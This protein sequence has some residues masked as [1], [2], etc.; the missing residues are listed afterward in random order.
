MCRLCTSL[1]P[2]FLEALPAVVIEDTPAACRYFEDVAQAD[3]SAILNHHAHME[4]IDVS[5]LS[6]LLDSE[7]PDGHPQTSAS[8]GKKKGSAGCARCQTL[9]GGFLHPMCTDSVSVS[10][11]SGTAMSQTLRSTPVQHATP[12]N[13]VSAGF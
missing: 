10:C 13:E 7:Q 6:A 5:A 4:D 11:V 3:V 12:W 8:P 1:H 2:E 9:A